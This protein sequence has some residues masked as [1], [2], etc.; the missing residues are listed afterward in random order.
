[1]LDPTNMCYYVS[2]VL[3]IG[4]AGPLFMVLKMFNLCIIFIS[5]MFS[6]TFMLFVSIF[7]FF[8]SH[9]EVKLYCYFT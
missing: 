2:E 7:L 5:V 8:I 4:R 6:S 9:E 1:M 3:D